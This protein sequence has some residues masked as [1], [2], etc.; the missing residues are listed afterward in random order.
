MRI[1]K[2]F[3]TNENYIENKLTLTTNAV[4]T[5]KWFYNHV[6]EHFFYKGY[7]IS[8]RNF[9]NVNSFEQLTIRFTDWKW[10]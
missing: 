6:L 9:Q 4:K 8:F 10:T 5:Q 3:L 1:L 7:K 2:I